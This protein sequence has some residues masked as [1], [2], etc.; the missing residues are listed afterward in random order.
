MAIL[1]R[2]KNLDRERDLNNVIIPVDKQIYLEN[3]K[4]VSISD[5]TDFVLSGFTGTTI[6]YL[7]TGTTTVQV[8]GIQS[9]TTI[10][11]WT[12]QQI[13][14]VMFYSTG[15]TTTTTTT[16]APTTTTT[17]T[18]APTTTTTTLAPTT[19]TTT[20]APTT[21]TTTTSITNYLN[22][23]SYS[24]DVVINGVSVSDVP[25]TW[26]SGSIFP[27][28]VLESTVGTYIGSG[29]KEVKISYSY[30]AIEQS[31]L[32]T[33]SSISECRD[34]TGSSPT[35]MSI[36][37]NFPTVGNSLN[38]WAMTENCPPII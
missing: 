17:T 6:Y 29:V 35:T 2:I 11:N 20:L 32:L 1:I 33:D 7:H 14:D 4:K 34:V 31:F 10:N 15:T 25:I 27:L 38:I 9:G 13:F 5:L 28:N 24:Y 37:V 30:T 21:T 22:V 26:Y 23:A 3:A 36:W 12:I 19:T 8:G 16:L 18:I